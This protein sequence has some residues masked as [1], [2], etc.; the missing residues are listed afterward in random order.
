MC[1]PLVALNSTANIMALCNRFPKHSCENAVCLHDHITYNLKLSDSSIQN[2]IVITN[3][4]K[5]LAKKLIF[6]DSI[7]IFTR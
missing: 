5:L 1:A 3:S 4:Y 7:F 2:S 6:V